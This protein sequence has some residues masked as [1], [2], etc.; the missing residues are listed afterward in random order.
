[1][2]TIKSLPQLLLFF[3]LASVSVAG[4]SEEGVVS[5][6]DSLFAED[7]GSPPAVVPMQDEHDDQVTEKGDG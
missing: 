4:G 2:A 6:R 1:M 3:L 5:G 7:D